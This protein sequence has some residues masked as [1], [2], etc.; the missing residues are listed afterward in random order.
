MDSN[1]TFLYAVLNCVKLYNM[2]TCIL[3][4]FYDS[5]TTCYMRQQVIKKYFFCSKMHV[6]LVLQLLNSYLLLM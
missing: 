6:I 4:V 1:D 5:M 3:A 2:D